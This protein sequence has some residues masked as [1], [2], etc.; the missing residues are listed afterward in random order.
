MTSLHRGF[1][2]DLPFIEQ[3]L[4]A[5]M[6]FL[7]MEECQKA[8]FELRADAQ[9]RLNVAAA[10]PLARLDAFSVSRVATRV[11]ALARSLLRDLSP[12]D[13]V[14]G[15]HCCAMFCLTLV[16]EG[17]LDDK[18]NMAVLLSLMLIHDAENDQTDEQGNEAV[19]SLKLA[20]W[21]SAARKLHTRAA[22]QGVFLPRPRN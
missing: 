2:G 18:T 12:E 7:M 6:M 16:D 15:L 10:A 17:C 1:D 8:G 19:T 3:A 9:H 20:R 21:K 4:P 14:E 22:V 11:D 13:A 5:H